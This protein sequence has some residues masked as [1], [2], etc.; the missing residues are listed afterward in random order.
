MWPDKWNMCELSW[1]KRS[2][3]QII[4]GPFWWHMVVRWK[5][6]KTNLELCFSYVNSTWLGPVTAPCSVPFI[7]LLICTPKLLILGGTVAKFSNV[8]NY[9][10][11]IIF[12][13]FIFV[14]T[15]LNLSSRQQLK[16]TWTESIHFTINWSK[17]NDSYQILMVK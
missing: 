6:N 14:V 10:K 8:T 11:L 5:E 9:C 2:R 17:V 13:L 3:K 4:L 12:R 16:D 15:V 1:L 7:F